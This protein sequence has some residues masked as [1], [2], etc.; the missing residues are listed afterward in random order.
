MVC[1]FVKNGGYRIMRR[2][3]KMKK[4]LSLLLA[5]AMLLSLAACGGEKTP[6]ANAGN[7]APASGNETPA[8]EPV[9]AVDPFAPYEETVTLTSFFEISGPIVNTFEESQLEE[10]P[11][12]RFIREQTNVEID[13][14]WY[15]V[16]SAEDSTTKKNTAIA[17]GDIP[18]FMV[19]NDAQ[20]A[21]LAKTD[22]INRDMG[23]IFD[24][25]ANDTLKAWTL[26]MDGAAMGAA[27]HNGDI[28]AVPLA[29][30]SMG[31][32]P[33]MWIRQDWL[34]NLGLEAP[35]TLDELYNV[36]KAFTENDPDGNGQND[37]YGISM[38]KS[39]LG[40]GVC[41]A[42][43][44]FNGF[45]AY[46]T[47]WIPDG[48][49][50]LK[51]GV[52]AQETRDALAFLAKCYADGLISEAF[53]T[54]DDGGVTEQ[55][56]SGEAGLCFGANWNYAWPLGMTSMNNPDADWTAY[57]IPGISEGGKAQ[58]S[59]N[60]GGFVVVSAECE[61]PEAVV[62]LLNAYADAIAN[63]TREEYASYLVENYTGGG[64]AQVPQH[65]VMLK[66]ISMTN[67]L[68]IHLA[69]KEALEKEDPSILNAENII[70]YDQIMAFRNGDMS[71]VIG[72][73][74][75]GPEGSSMAAINAY[76]E[77]GAVEVDQF[78]GASTPTMGKKMSTVTDKVLEYFTK[79]IMGIE[80][81][82]SYDAFLAE[83]NDL[84]LADITKEVNE[85]YA[86]K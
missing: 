6:A 54:M 72:N 67:E 10:L 7:D 40:M 61:H 25:Y 41:D 45:G 82:D 12:L 16:S 49:G 5:L 70:Y 39:F 26:G 68:D 8:D 69:V 1:G 77:A 36:M 63:S 31:T 66:G 84:G 29:A 13:Y 52:D 59:L 20:L 17:T 78:T 19:V 3:L 79:V 35:K 4:I 14:L 74:T 18:D 34:N 55:V 57:A 81:L 75:Y 38:L 37:T 24:T 76:F 28:I 44:I 56:A 71:Q 33:V 11:M 48:N 22:L 51:Y 43:G 65:H 2:N 58:S 42:I 27:T 83:L 21:L 60:L 64:V 85:W 53:S 15:A 62:K 30:S 50:G 80:S 46:P 86:T 23:A 9:V 73:K 32:V 47:H